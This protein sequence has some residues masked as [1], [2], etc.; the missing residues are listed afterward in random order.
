MDSSEG[1]KVITVYCCNFPCCGKEYASKF[2]LRR[3]VNVF[4]FN[5]KK[6]QCSICLKY[7]R[8]NQNLREHKFIHTKE[9]PYKCEVC[10]VQLRHKSALLKHVRSHYFTLS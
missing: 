7:F 3:H 1:L 6:A 8:N 10:Q 5:S 4:H 9:K 2:N